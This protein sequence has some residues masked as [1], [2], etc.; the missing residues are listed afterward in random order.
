M[1]IQ[2]KRIVSAVCALALC[3]S[4][5]PASALAE[6]VVSGGD[7]AIVQQV[8]EDTSVPVTETTDETTEPV[9]VADAA[10]TETDTAQPAEDASENDTL[11]DGSESEATEPETSTQ[12]E[13]TEQSSADAEQPAT[14]DASE[15]EA[16]AA[17][18]EQ[19]PMALADGI[20]TYASG[21]S[22]TIQKVYNIDVGGQVKI[23][24]TSGVGT[25]SHSWAIVAGDAATLSGNNGN[26]TVTGKPGQVGTVILRHSYREWVVS[27]VDEYF[28]VNIGNG[29]QVFLFIAKP[30][31]TTLS[32]NGSD[33]YFLTCGGQA[34]DKA[35][36]DMP[37]V[38]D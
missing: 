34:S 32:S 25:S 30:G 6:P 7:T 28:Q 18:E 33:Y 12:P 35:S 19:A 10:E 3:A 36:A 1:K 14:S 38:V 24:G 5:M 31:N 15:P 26:A 37:V 29:G 11:E 9:D 2:F 13:E 27:R 4:M 20:E 22:Y 17:V 8:E 21:A 23:N 16:A